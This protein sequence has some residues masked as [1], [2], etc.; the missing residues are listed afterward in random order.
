MR[1]EALLILLSRLQ[2]S[3]RMLSSISHHVEQNEAIMRRLSDRIKQVHREYDVN[4]SFESSKR[5]YVMPDID[6]MIA[7]TSYRPAPVPVLSLKQQ[8]ESTSN[9]VSEEEILRAVVEEV[10]DALVDGLA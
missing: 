6:A 10:V 7:K 4:P 3:E 2:R 9:L 5:Q 1:E 8:K